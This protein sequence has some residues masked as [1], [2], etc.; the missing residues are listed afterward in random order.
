MI[1]PHTLG[2]DQQIKGI[3]YIDTVRYKYKQK[4]IVIFDILIY[5]NTEMDTI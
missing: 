1:N 3:K 4:W 5:G 2:K